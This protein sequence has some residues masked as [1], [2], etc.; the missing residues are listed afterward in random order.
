MTA[1]TDR[2]NAIR[3]A[4]RPTHGEEYTVFGDETDD[5]PLG[6]MYKVPFGG[7]WRFCPYSGLGDEIERP[8]RAKL[9]ASIQRRW[10]NRRGDR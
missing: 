3:A 1:G 6:L 5:L 10:D 8:T 4:P 7:G 9:E 2:K